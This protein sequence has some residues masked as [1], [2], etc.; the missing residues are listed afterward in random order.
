ME[1]KIAPSKVVNRFAERHGILIEDMGVSPLMVV[2]WGRAMTRS[3]AEAAGAKLCEKWMWHDKYKLYKGQVNGHP[4]SFGN[5]PTGA[6]GTVMV[7]EEMIACGARLFI[8]YGIAGSLQSKAP[9]GTAIIPTSCI[10]EEGTSRHYLDPLQE[11]TASVRLAELLEQSCR[12]EGLVA[13]KGPHWTT[14][15]IYRETEEKIKTYAQSCL[16][17]TSDA[18][19]N[20]E[21]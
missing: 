16:L 13:L 14:D 21:V 19:D 20:R 6:P 4:V 1:E 2:S 17:Y 8:G 11:I 12:K 15:A 9:I 3:L 18:A 7:M 5:V 10:S